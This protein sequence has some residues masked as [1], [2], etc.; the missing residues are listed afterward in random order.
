MLL[1]YGG[2]SIK[3]NGAYDDV[4]AALREAGNEVIELSGV[5]PNPRLDKVFRRREPG[6]GARGEPDPA[7]GGGSVIDCAKFISLGSGLGEDEDLWYDYVETGK[8]APENLVPLGVVLTPPSPAPRWAAW[9][10][11]PTGPQPQARLHILPADAE[12]LG[13][14]PDLSAHP[15]G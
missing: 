11:S 6:S 3:R 7:V 14:R 8:P 13:T 1:V 9:L 2:G 12:V 5:T 15:A 4:T 10:C